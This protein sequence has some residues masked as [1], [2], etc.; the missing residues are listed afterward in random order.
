MNEQGKAADLSVDGAA[1][2][3]DLLPRLLRFHSYY[4]CK[5]DTAL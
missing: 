2:P 5:S 4:D 1:A 3:L